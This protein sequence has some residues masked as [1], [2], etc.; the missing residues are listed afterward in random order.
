[1]LKQDASAQAAS[2]AQA[3]GNGQASAFA[4]AIAQANGG[5]AK[6]AGSAI[7]QA[8]G[9][10]NTNAIAN[11]LAQASSKGEVWETCLHRLLPVQHHLRILRHDPDP[12]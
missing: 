12:C 11:A 5:T 6:A 2:L 3:L 1:V 9:E 8:A 7:A 4:Q 10:G